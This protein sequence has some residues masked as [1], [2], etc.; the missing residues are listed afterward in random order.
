[1]SVSKLTVLSAAL[2]LGLAVLVAAPQGA[3]AKRSRSLLKAKVAGIAFKANQPGTPN[4]AFLVGGN[5][6]LLNGAQRKGLKSFNTISLVCQA[7]GGIQVGATYAC[8]GGFTSTGLRTQQIRG[9]TSD[10]QVLVTVTSF[11]GTTVA[12]TFAGAF[13][14]VGDTNPGDG[15]ASV[16]KG[17]FKVTLLS[18]G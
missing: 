13:E 15:P 3:D 4:G 17:K 16:S 7:P 10:D 12:G 2:T 6:F 9:W 14:N 11:D 8:G 18:A 5:G 1:M